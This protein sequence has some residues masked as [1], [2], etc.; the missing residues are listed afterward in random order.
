MGR[1]DHLGKPVIGRAIKRFLRALVLP[2]VLIVALLWGMFAAMDHF[3]ALENAREVE[4]TAQSEAEEDRSFEERIEPFHARRIDPA[5]FG[6]PFTSDLEELTRVAPRAPQSE[7]EPTEGGPDGILLYQPLVIGAGRL[8]FGGRNL[9]LAGIDPTP[10]DRF[11]RDASGEGYW[12]CGMMARTAF[13]NHLRGRAVHCD[14][15]SREWEGTAVTTCSLNNND[16]A[17]WLVEQG[18]AEVAAGSSY[19][20][21]GQAAREAGRGLYG[22]DPR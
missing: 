14:I 17:A 12:P 20:D 7:P 5:D 15:D 8:S 4:A 21:L 11:C 9:E 10:A 22:D 3:A 1:P 16:L 13:R 18:W 6:Q 19:T 2:A